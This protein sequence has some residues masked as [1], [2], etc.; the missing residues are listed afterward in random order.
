MTLLVLQP[1]AIL[2]LRRV[3][4]QKTVWLLLTWFKP[5]PVGVCNHTRGGSILTQPLVLPCVLNVLQP[6][7]KILRV[8][9]DL[10]SKQTADKG[11]LKPVKDKYE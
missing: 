2:S 10:L 6:Y 9:A 3:E 7:P 8:L 4:Q 11:L 5:T 1:C